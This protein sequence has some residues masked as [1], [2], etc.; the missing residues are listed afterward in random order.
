MTSNGFVTR[1]FH[2]FH[3]PEGSAPCVVH[4]RRVVKGKVTVAGELNEIGDL[5]LVPGFVIHVPAPE[6]L[7]HEHIKRITVLKNELRVPAG[8]ILKCPSNSSFTVPDNSL[9]VLVNP[10]VLGGPI[11]LTKPVSTPDVLRIGSSITSTFD[12]VAVDGDVSMPDASAPGPSSSAPGPSP[13]VRSG[14]RATGTPPPLAGVILPRALKI[15]DKILPAGPINVAITNVTLPVGF[16]FDAFTLFPE[17]FVVPANSILPGGFWLPPGTVVP[18]GTSF[19]PGSIIPT[20]T[21][22]P[23]DTRVPTKVLQ[24]VLGGKE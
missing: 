23:K 14:L 15:K 3:V 7:E 9:F 16:K 24:F 19:G 18:G 1:I 22:L 13:P 20:G 17:S 8:G 10:I 6:P 12:R 11:T 21:A 2:K 5:S 4:D